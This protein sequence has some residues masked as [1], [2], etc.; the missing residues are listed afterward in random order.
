MSLTTG[1]CVVGG[2]LCFMAFIVTTIVVIGLAVW[3]VGAKAK[4][5]GVVFKDGISSEEAEMVLDAINE[6]L[7]AEKMAET[8]M[9]FQTAL[10]K[11][12]AKKVA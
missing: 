1:L 2:G 3:K 7:N 11:A 10:S 12:A 9:K 8:F 5:K 6:T 4:S